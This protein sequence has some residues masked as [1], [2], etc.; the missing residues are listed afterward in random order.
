LDKESILKGLNGVLPRDI[1][2]IKAEE[3]DSKFNARF[4]AKSRSY[5]YRIF[6]GR[7]AVL[8][9]YTW[10]VLYPLDLKKIMEAT[11]LISNEHDFSSFCVA[12]SAKEDNTCRV[13]F[14]EWES[15][16]EELIFRIEADRFL[17]SMVRSLVGTLIEVGRGYFS[18]ADFE[19][20]LKA[21]DRTKAGPTAPA[22]GLYLTEVKY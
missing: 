4:S 5:K 8:R 6:K 13:I 19:D 9:R 7:T 11:G 15:C 12:E 1:L 22:C 14:S 20:I 3:V 2:I 17:H 21:R 16:G 10:E 18:M